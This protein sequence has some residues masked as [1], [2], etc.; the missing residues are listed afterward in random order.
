MLLAG[1]KEKERM[2]DL[3]GFKKAVGADVY[4]LQEA[5]KDLSSVPIVPPGSLE[6]V[7]LLQKHNREIS[8][9]AAELNTKLR[10]AHNT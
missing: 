9:L 2:R 5:I 3:D 7:K 6:M 4:F 1:F 8:R 10:K